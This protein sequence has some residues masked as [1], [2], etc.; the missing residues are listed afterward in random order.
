MF[1]PVTIEDDV[2]LGFDLRQRGE[3]GGGGRLG[4]DSRI[5]EGDDCRGDLAL[6]TW[7]I[8]S[9][10]SFSHSTAIGIATRT[11]RPS[12][13]VVQRYV[14]TARPARHDSAI[15]GA[16]SET[17]PMRRVPGARSPI[18]RPMPAS[19]A[20][21]PRDDDR[22]RPLAELVED[23]HADRGVAVELSRLRAVFEE[24]KPSLGC[25]RETRLLRVVDVRADRTTRAPSRSRWSSFVRLV[26]SGA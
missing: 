19:S 14:S 5:G 8:A 24:R 9:A 6:E 26:T 1:L 4:A 2:A 20:R 16:S 11:A 7:S 12:A 18:A 17:T 25:E 23:L 10:A 13:I 22:R 15:T 21:F 3:R